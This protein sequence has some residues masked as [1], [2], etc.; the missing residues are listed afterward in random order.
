MRKRGKEKGTGIGKEKEKEKE[1][2]KENEKEIGTG[3]GTG[4]ET[5]TTE[6]GIEREIE[7][8]TARGIT[9]IVGVGSLK[10]RSAGGAILLDPVGRPL[11]SAFQFHSLLRARKRFHG[12]ARK[13]MTT[14][15]D[16]HK[17]RSC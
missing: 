8:E 7:I 2:A 6:T 17:H 15:Y 5:E 13:I 10:S 11:L 3:T 4:R 1:S 16:E 12:T 14:W 9:S